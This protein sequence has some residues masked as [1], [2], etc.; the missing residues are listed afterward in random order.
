MLRYIGPQAHIDN[1]SPQGFNEKREP[2]TNT[3]VHKSVLSTRAA[4]RP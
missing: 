1:V 3:V 2:H 4:A